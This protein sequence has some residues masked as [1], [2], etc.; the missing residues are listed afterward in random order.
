MVDPV[1]GEVGF[2]WL[3]LVRGRLSVVDP[4]WGR[5]SVVDPVSGKLTMHASPCWPC[6]KAS[7]SRASDCEIEPRFPL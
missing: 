7:A 6:G 1:W 5:L 2:Q 4:V 3:I